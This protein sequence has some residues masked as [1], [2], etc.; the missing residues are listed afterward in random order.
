MYLLVGVVQLIA[1]FSFFCSSNEWVEIIEPSSGEKMFT[2]P[3]SG[4]IV[5]EP[6]D[7][8]KM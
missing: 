3:T 5:F 7:G 2:N 1:I 8:A 6:P 4:D